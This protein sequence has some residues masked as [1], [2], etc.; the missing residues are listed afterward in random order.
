[1]REDAGARLCVVTGD[2]IPASLPLDSVEIHPATWDPAFIIDAYRSADFFVLP[3]YLETWGNVLLEAMAFGLPCIGVEGDA[4][5]EIIA[6]QTGFIIPANNPPALAE[7]M[8]QLF[9]KQQL[10]NQMGAFARQRI[11]TTFTWNQVAAQI[12]AAIS[13]R[14]TL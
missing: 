14:K 11:E 8:L 6:E 13:Q 7:A 2:P 5:S 3:S 12:Y 10:R 4:M 1:V 9:E